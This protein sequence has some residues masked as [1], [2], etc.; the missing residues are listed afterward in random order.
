[1]QKN[2]IRIF[3]IVLL[4]GVLSSCS[5]INPG[6]LVYND[7]SHP[8]F[9]I[10]NFESSAFNEA[11]G[12]FTYEVV[13]SLSKKNNQDLITYALTITPITDEIYNDVTVT[14]SLDE[15]WLDVLMDKNRTTLYFGTDKKAPIRMDRNSQ[16]SKGLMADIGK[17]LEEGAPLKEVEELLKSPVKVRIKYQE[18]LISRKVFPLT[19]LIYEDKIK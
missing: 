10:E 18:H 5:L 13:S 2:K 14:A 4:I 6:T 9:D 16:S 12:P 19:I 1:M 8:I 17:Y 15:S 7:R 3:W 11:D